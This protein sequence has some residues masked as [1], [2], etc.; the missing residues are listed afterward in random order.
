[1]KYAAAITALLA[2]LLFTVTAPPTI[3]FGDS[4]EIVSAAYTLGIAHP[5]A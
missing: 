4:G 5:P 3:Y 2:A 1:M